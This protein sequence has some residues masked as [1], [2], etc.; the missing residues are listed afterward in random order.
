MPNSIL[1]SQLQK[2]FFFQPF[3]T[4]DLN[5]IMNLTSTFD[6]DP[7]TDEKL[8]KDT[9]KRLLKNIETEIH[10]WVKKKKKNERPIS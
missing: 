10:L 4:R 5:F 6:L 7:T 2:T 3:P 8:I 9:W 1:L